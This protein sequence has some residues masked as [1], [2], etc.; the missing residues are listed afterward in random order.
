MYVVALGTGEEI[1]LARFTVSSGTATNTPAWSPDGLRVAAY[2]PANTA[3][4]IYLLRAD[5]SDHAIIAQ[6]GGRGYQDL[7]W[8]ADGRQV[9]ITSLYQGI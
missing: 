5:G 6:T 7:A 1:E 4:G 9:L 8:S 2:S 3:P